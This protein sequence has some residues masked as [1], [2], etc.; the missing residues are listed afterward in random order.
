VRGYAHL[1]GGHQEGWPDAFTNI[2][3]DVYTFIA[4]GKKATDPRPPA[5]ASF[6]DGFRANAVVEAIL[7]SAKQGSVWTKVSY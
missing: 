5:F 1:P 3:R 4:E 7:E 2:M 6:E